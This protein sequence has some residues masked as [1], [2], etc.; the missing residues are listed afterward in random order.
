VRDDDTG[1]PYY[2]FCNLC[3]RPTLKTR[4]QLPAAVPPPIME[5]PSVP[6]DAA[7]N[8]GAPAE[9]NLPVATKEAVP[10]VIQAAAFKRLVPFGFG[11]SRLGPQGRAA[12]A[13]LLEEARS[14]ERIHVRGYADILGAMPSNKR[15]ALAR[16][17]AIRAYLIQGGISPDIITVSQCFDCFIESNE[18]EE[19]RAANRRA[20]VVM[21]PSRGALDHED[22]DRRD[23]YRKDVAGPTATVTPSVTTEGGQS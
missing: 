5:R 7:K 10:V 8:V 11:R 1:E 23:P 13:A 17:E 15:L 21:R 16:A 14:V 12:M 2:V 18:T 22:L 6:V 4:Y 9:D 20:V 3:S 19:G